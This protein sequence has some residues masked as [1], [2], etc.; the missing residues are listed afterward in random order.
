MM[1]DGG[2]GWATQR[3]RG[4]HL[5]WTVFTGCQMGGGGQYARQ[6]FSRPYS[7]WNGRDPSAKCISKPVLVVLEGCQSGKTVGEEPTVEIDPENLSSPFLSFCLFLYF[8]CSPLTR[9]GEFPCEWNR[10]WSSFDECCWY[11]GSVEFV[12]HSKMDDGWIADRNFG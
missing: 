2:T 3:R 9:L 11:R 5:R 4:A 6:I 7:C 12:E 8:G 10:D 1:C